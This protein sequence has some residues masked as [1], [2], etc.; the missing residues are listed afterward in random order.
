MEY[1]AK[2]FIQNY[3]SILLLL[4][5]IGIGSLI[6][7]FF[8]H[9]V[10]NLKPIGDIFLNLLFVSVIPLVF[11]AIA[12]SVANIEGDS[13]LG[14]IIGM[15]SLVFVIGIVVAGVTSV[16]FL[17]LFPVSSDLPIE[18]AKEIIDTATQDSWG[19]K[20]V[21]FLTVSEFSSLLSRQNMLAFVIFSFLVG[22]ATRKSG[23]AADMFRKFINSGNAVMGNLLVMVMKLA[24]IGL[25][26]YFAY[27]VGTLGPQLFGF[28]AK[29]IGLYYIFG[30]F[31][32]FTVFS[33][34]AFLAFGIKGVKRYWQNNILPSLTALS[35]CSSLATMP[36]N[37]LAAK[38]IGIPDTVASVVIP[39][40]T[41]LHKHGSAIACIFKIYVALLLSGKEFFDPTNLVMAVGITLLVSIVAGGIPNGGY[42]GEMLIISVYQMPTEVIPSI[43][44]I[45]TLVDPLATML[46]A[47]GDTVAAMLTTRL[48]GQKLSDPITEQTVSSG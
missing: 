31:Y 43:M 35:S 42:I 4:L 40:G 38:Q 46:N 11:F 17:Y 34:F 22:I 41:T 12:S 28:Y 37:L 29:P 47:T 48:I 39:L 30:L 24:P 9:F 45:A 16:I 1:S 13:V 27:Q 26:A 6:G 10:N 36:A 23:S 2:T 15:M 19:E 3:G 7:V 33:L 25:G 44:I 8:P 21:R 14:R 20:M 18:Q 5:G 32:F